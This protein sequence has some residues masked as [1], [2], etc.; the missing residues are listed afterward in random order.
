MRDR[1]VRLCVLLQALRSSRRGLTVAR[2]MEETGS[3]RATVYRDLK[4]LRDAGLV[5]EREL[6]NGQAR[7]RIPEESIALRGLAVPQ[8]VAIAVAR[9]ALAALEGTEIVTA[10][11]RI[12]SDRSAPNRRVHARS[13]ARLRRPDILRSIERA[14][15]DHRRL[16]ILYRG[17]RDSTWRWREVDPGAIQLHDGEPYLW[18][19]A[20]DRA[21]WRTFKV[22]RIREVEI[23]AE[24]ALPHPG[25]A[26][27]LA[28]PHA[29]R[30]WSAPP[31]KVVVRIAPE[32]A[33]LAGEHPLVPDQRL[34]PQPDGAVF[35]RATVA[36][37]VE[38]T[39]WI[40]RWGAHAHGARDLEP[41]VPRLR[42][43]WRQWSRSPVGAS[44]R[45]QLLKVGAE[46]VAL[47]VVAANNRGLTDETQGNPATRTFASRIRRGKR[48]TATPRPLRPRPVRSSNAQGPG[49][50]PSAARCCG[51]LPS[52]P[53][54]SGVE[55]RPSDSR[56]RGHPLGSLRRVAEVLHPKVVFDLQ[57]ANRVRVEGADVF[58]PAPIGRGSK[59]DSPL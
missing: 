45:T 50:T 36:G 14:T 5:I 8:L 44:A 19:W 10:L 54:P 46:V 24:S 3:C 30:V 37:L 27:V 42:D 33:W 59:G 17:V 11:D 48:M 41:L 29:V 1:I 16:R 9:D 12:L 15:R 4:V 49:A 6:V 28:L 43:A 21:A 18:A 52:A 13:T 7:H 47:A 20:L 34:E 38:A 2:L 53:M 25:L 23:Q 40:L 35:V 26:D 51:C 39:R 31:I 57:E 32:V 55:H 56:S 58:F 22:A